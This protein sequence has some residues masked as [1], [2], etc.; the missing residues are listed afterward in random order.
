MQQCEGWHP[1]IDAV[2]PRVVEPVALDP[3]G[4]GDDLLELGGPVDLDPDAL[5][6]DFTVTD[7]DLRSL[8][9]DGVNP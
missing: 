3:P 6:G 8:I 7:I 9:E 1:S 5:E 4:L 2:H